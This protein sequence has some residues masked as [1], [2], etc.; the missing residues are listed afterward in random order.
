M[1]VPSLAEGRSMSV[2]L[3]VA[4]ACAAETGPLTDEAE[5]PID[6]G[7]ADASGETRVRVGETSV[8]VRNEIRRETRDDGR[9]VLQV[10]GRASRNITDGSAFVFDDVKGDWASLG[11]RSFEVTYPTDDAG[12]LEGGD[13]FVR[14][15]FVPSAGR[16]D[17]LTAKVVAR[18]RLGGFTGDGVWLDA[19]VRP[20][21]S[22]GRVVWRISGRAASP[23][24]GLRVRA[25]D[26][27]LDDVEQLSDRDFTVD[28]ARDH[29]TALVGAAGAL[30]FEA[31]LPDGLHTKTARLG[32]RLRSL[33]LTAGDPYE[34]WPPPV[35]E[36][37]VRA[38]LDALPSGTLDLSSCGEAIA[39]R[40]CAGQV[41][42]SFDDVAFAAALSRAQA[43][44]A[45]PDGFVADAPALIGADR[46]LEYGYMVGETVQGELEG[47]FGTWYPDEAARDAAADAAIDRAIDLAYAR[48][49]DIYGEPHPAAP[50]D[51]AGTRQVVADALLAHLDGLDLTQTEFGRSLDEL[52]DRFR[53]WHVTD[54]RTWRETVEPQDAGD[55]RDVYIGNWLNPYVEIKVVRATGVVEDVYFEID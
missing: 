22:G 23:L 38:C 37:E 51:L 7:K 5:V 48:P 32:L 40:A 35:C 34:V 13:H 26:L 27:Y 25:G 6:D 11:A 21:V 12:F 46:A 15:H 55:G 45:E 20:V 54:L 52:A 8:W 30:A 17:V 33:G 29:V 41:G 50:G 49:L 53:A 2:L 28:L 19:D 3:L 16:P 14:L 18:A 4:A 36:D 10:R 44:L 9:Q 1:P 47:L 42:V 24:Q 39:V 31:E 43:I